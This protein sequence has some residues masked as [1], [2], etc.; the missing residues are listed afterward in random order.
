MDEDIVIGI[1]R[2]EDSNR[3]VESVT[4]GGLPRA[5]I[6]DAGWMI[7]YSDVPS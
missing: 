6:E 3:V 7:V 1:R 5:Q 2:G 4:S